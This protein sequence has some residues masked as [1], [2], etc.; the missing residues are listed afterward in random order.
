M[1]DIV[2][3]LFYKTLQNRSPS[4]PHW[5]TTHSE[6]N[7]QQ[8]PQLRGQSTGLVNQGSRVQIS[9]GAFP[10]CS[11][12]SPHFAFLSIPI[13]QIHLIVNKISRRKTRTYLPL[14]SRSDLRTTGCS[15][16]THVT[17]FLRVRCGCRVL[18]G[19]SISRQ[20][21]NLEMII[22]LRLLAIRGNG[23]WGDGAVSGEMRCFV[24]W[25][26]HGLDVCQY[27]RMY[28]FLQTKGNLFGH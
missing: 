12:F 24:R 13:M 10:F 26:S 11:F 9:L 14:P 19:Q 22:L 25:M 7:S 8:P 23:R 6:H 2:K 16:G 4:E 27:Y 21:N 28:N 5:K 1:Q 17:R 3:S 20:R 18:P 15:S